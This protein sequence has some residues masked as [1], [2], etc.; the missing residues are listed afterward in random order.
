MPKKTTVGIEKARDFAVDNPELLVI[1]ADPRDDTL[2]VSYRGE[3]MVGSFGGD[4]VARALT[5]E[6]F[7]SAHRTLTS[8]VMQATAKVMN[9]VLD[10]V[11][12]IGETLQTKSKDNGTTK[13]GRSA[14]RSK[15]G[16]ARGKGG[17]KRSA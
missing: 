3:A 9:A 11:Q 13:K 15:V 17:V 12:G 16:S 1:A 5:V 4:V 2:F 14:G 7:N 10:G 6:R 8:N